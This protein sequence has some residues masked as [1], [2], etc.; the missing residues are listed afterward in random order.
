MPPAEVW[1]W[2]DLGS[3]VLNAPVRPILLT[4]QLVEKLNSVLC[5][6]LCLKPFRWRPILRSVSPPALTRALEPAA[7][8][9]REPDVRASFQL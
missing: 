5:P 7:A 8:S 1:K 9:S 6:V 4:S 2:R 3:R